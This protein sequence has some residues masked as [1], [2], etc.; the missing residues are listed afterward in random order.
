VADRPWVTA[1]ETC[2]LVLALDAMGDRARALQLMRD[3]QFLRADD[4]GYWTGWVW[5]DE[6]M[7]PAEKSTWTAAAI[8]LAA[9]ALAGHSPAHRLFR[10]DGLPRLLDVRD[11]DQHCYA[12][13]GGLQ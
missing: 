6:V 7:W 12:L 13:A 3:V 1:A 10:G 11:C 9:D 2:E 8:I 4:G 5:P